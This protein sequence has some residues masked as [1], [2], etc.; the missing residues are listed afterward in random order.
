[1]VKSNQEV[2]VLMK[3]LTVLSNTLKILNLKNI[4]KDTSVCMVHTSY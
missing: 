4:L 2:T 1:M 3:Y